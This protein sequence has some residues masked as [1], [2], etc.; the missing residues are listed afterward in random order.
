MGRVPAVF[1]NIFC[2]R[3]TKILTRIVH[4]NLGTLWTTV[5]TAM[6]A[7]TSESFPMP[8]R[9]IILGVPTVFVRIF[10]VLKTK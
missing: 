8:N 9:I 7:R 3:I 10:V 6:T 5:F 4:I 2:V 1:A